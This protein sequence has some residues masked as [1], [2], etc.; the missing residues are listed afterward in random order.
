MREREA[1]RE[2]ALTGEGERER[3]RA[4]A[5]KEQREGNPRSLHAVS[6][7]PDMGFDPKNLEIMTRTDIK[8]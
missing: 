3:N 2:H 7:D 6:V 4:Y 8:S 1:E 5:E